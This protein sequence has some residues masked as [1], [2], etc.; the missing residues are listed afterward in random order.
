VKMSVFEPKKHHLREVLLY[1]FNAKKSA[2]ASHR[3]HV[4]AYSEAAL[5]ETA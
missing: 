3:L 4:K 2:V 5:S 1:F